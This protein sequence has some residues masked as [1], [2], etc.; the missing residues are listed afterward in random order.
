MTSTKLYPAG[1]SSC[2]HDMYNMCV[3]VCTHTCVYVYSIHAYVHQYI[4]HIID[5][6]CMRV[7][8]NN[9]YN[10]KI[11]MSHLYVLLFCKFPCSFVKYPNVHWLDVRAA[12]SHLSW[13]LIATS[14]SLRKL[15]FL[16]L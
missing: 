1:I 6:L 3:C 10:N 2:N 5:L 7:C 11:S 13:R 15:S 14:S 9:K 4:I 8:A 16:M 12:K